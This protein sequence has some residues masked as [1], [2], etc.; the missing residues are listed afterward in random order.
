MLSDWPIYFGGVAVLNGLILPL[1]HY[2]LQR[3]FGEEYILRLVDYTLQRLFGEDF[4]LPRTIWLFGEE[5]AHIEDEHEPEEHEPEEHE[6]E[7]HE[8]EEFVFDFE[9]EEED[10]PDF[11]NRNILLVTCKGYHHRHLVPCF[12]LLLYQEE[13]DEEDKS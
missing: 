1:T 8:P 7:E 9:E 11:V 3:L 12:F 13:E 6:P 10:A 4:L 5:R 2:T